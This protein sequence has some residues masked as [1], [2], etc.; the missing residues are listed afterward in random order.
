MTI[1]LEKHAA[2]LAINRRITA[3]QLEKI[4]S[5]AL[6][7]GLVRIIAQ[8]DTLSGHGAI[9]RQLNELPADSY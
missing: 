8:Q 1:L 2:E 4:N 9:N 5:D 6:N 7:D 3:T